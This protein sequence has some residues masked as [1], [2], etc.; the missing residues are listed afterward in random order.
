MLLRFFKIGTQPAISQNARAQTAA[1]FE[2]ILRAGMKRLI[3]P[4]TRSAFLDPFKFHT[5]QLETHT[6]EYV[7]IDSG[8][9]QVAQSGGRV[10]A[11]IEPG[12]ELFI[13]LERKK[14][15]LPF[16]IVSVVAEAVTFDSAPHEATDAPHF[17]RGMRVRRATVMPEVVMRGET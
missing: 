11:H 2:P 17:Q 7:E 15:D 6:D 3:H 12:A 5:L 1:T 10:I 13:K 16:V 9:H 4:I 14:S 8:R